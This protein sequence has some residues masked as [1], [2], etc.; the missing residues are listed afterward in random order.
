MAR[1][2]GISMNKQLYKEE[3]EKI[4]NLIQVIEPQSKEPISFEEIPDS[5]KGVVTCLIVVVLIIISMITL[6][7]IWLVK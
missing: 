1:L 3:S 5:G 7:T 6:L 2:E 4:Q